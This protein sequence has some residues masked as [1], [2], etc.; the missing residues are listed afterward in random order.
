M[1]FRIFVALGDGASSRQGKALGLP[2][3]LIEEEG[4]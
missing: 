4:G 2:L 1:L 3:M